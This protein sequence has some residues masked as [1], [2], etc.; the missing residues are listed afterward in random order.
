MVYENQVNWVWSRLGELNTKQLYDVLQARQ[1]V[2]VVEQDC[3]YL[4]ADGV[5]E[6]SWHLIGYSNDKLQAYCRVVDAGIKYKELSIGRVLTTDAARGRGLGKTLMKQAIE[7]IDKTYGDIAV[8]ISAQQYL[9]NYYQS[10]GFNTVSTPYD[11]DGIPHVE[12]FR[13]AN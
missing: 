2:F 3:V 5:D 11:E 4:D 13:P 1:Q 9:E 12:M 8:R 10:F 6:N 7:N